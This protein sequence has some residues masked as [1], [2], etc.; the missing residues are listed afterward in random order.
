MIRLL[1]SIIISGKIWDWGKNKMTMQFDENGKFVVPEATL[2]ISPEISKIIEKAKGFDKKLNKKAYDLALNQIKEFNKKFPKDKL[3]DLKFEDY[4]Y[5]NKDS[6]SYWVDMNTKEVAHMFHDGFNREFG[7]WHSNKDNKYYITSG[8]NSKNVTEDVAR[9]RFEEVKQAIISMISYI[10]KNSFNDVDEDKTIW[11]Q[12][13]AKIIYL[14]FPD[15]VLPFCSKEL[16]REGCEIFGVPFDENDAIK[17]NNYLL[18]K[19]K[20][21]PIFKEWHTMKLAQFIYF[22]LGK[23][24]HKD[25]QGE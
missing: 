10:N 3:S 19:I 1:K 17:S 11:H 13:K 25:V 24:W 23:D 18:M 8:V 22:L 6:F 4:L 5:S 16:V 12:I 21:N 7:V 20:K 14:Y 2:E 15:K 9:R